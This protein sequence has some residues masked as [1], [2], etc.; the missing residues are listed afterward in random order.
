ML[1]TI[2]RLSVSGGLQLLS[3]AFCS[4]VV[5][6]VVYTR[7]FHPL[8]KFPGPFLASVT[9]W[10]YFFS[11]RLKFIDNHRYTLHRRYDTPACRAVRI[12]PNAVSISDPRAMDIAFGHHPLWVKSEFY[13]S[14]NPHISGGRELFSMRS[15][16]DHGPL[17]R[18]VG[19]LFSVK[20]MTDYEPCVDRTIASFRRRLDLASQGGQTVALPRLF[21][22]YTL[23]VIGEVFWG[24]EGGFGGLVN[25]VD[26]KSWSWMLSNMIG[27]LSV[28]GYAPRGMRTLYLLTQLASSSKV[29][30]GISSHEKLVQEA[31]DAVSQKVRERQRRKAGD[32]EK[33]ST[34]GAGTP[35]S[36]MDRMLDIVDET[37]HKEGPQK[38]TEG[39]TAALMYDML[40]GGFDTTSIAL[41]HAFYNLLRNPHYFA[42][43]RTEIDAAYADGTLPDTGELRYLDTLKLPFL[44]ACI[45]ESW[46]LTMGVFGFPRTVPPG[47]CALPDGTTLPGGVDVTLN[48][49][50]VHFA[51]EIFGERPEEYIPERWLVDTN[52]KD[53]EAEKER[54]RLMEHYF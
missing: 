10:W 3:V 8:S 52:V 33:Q 34:A 54:V 38:F 50:V 46:R 18:I 12:R 28:T 49:D 2:L 13:E 22:Q 51:T 30:G 35:R 16:A 1:D 25:D 4:Y 43:L 23:D 27:P 5:I 39:D 20:T 11:L 36:L 9:D 6:W 47:G 14:F 44:G 37:A 19:P 40:M 53:Q 21:S 26:Y 15:G 31:K 48:P 41:Q 45:Q 24:K 29:R 42:K 7:F 17:K 32:P